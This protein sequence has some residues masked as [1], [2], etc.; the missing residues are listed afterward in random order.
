MHDP[1]IGCFHYLLCFPD[2]SS[3]ILLPYFQAA[4]QKYRPSQDQLA[5]YMPLLE[6]LVG[7]EIYTSNTIMAI[8]AD[9]AR[10]ISRVTEENVSAA[11]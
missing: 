10:I 4:C 2:S 7:N 5:P 3:V 6:Q 8:I 9:N 11:Y 1:S